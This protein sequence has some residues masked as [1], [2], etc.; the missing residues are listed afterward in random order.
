MERWG[1]IH[2][3]VIYPNYFK[4]EIAGMVCY[5]DARAVENLKGLATVIGKLVEGERPP[6]SHL[7]VQFPSALLYTDAFIWPIERTDAL[8]IAKEIS[9]LEENGAAFVWAHSR[10]VAVCRKGEVVTRRT[11]ADFYIEVDQADLDAT[12][13]D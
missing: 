10:T 6:Y 2:D 12:A 9:I 5:A 4:V 13:L 7:S 3:G 8:K 1:F 11:L